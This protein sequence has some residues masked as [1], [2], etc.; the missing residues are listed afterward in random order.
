L[1]NDIHILQQIK[2]LNSKLNDF[3]F[4]Y[5][6][7]L[8]NVVGLLIYRSTRIISIFQ[9]SVALAFRQFGLSSCSWVNR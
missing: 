3:L 9:V 2:Q 8:T 1:D 7:S 5:A 6:I 4:C